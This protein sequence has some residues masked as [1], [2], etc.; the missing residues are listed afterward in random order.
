MRLT[1]FALALTIILL[2]ITSYLAWEGQQEIKGLKREREFD[3]EQLRAEKTAKPDQGSLIPLPSAPAASITP[4]PSPGTIAL[5][6]TAPPAEAMAGTS[7]LPGGGLTIP[8][9]VAEAESKGIS[10]NTVTPLQKQILASLPIAKVKTVV[11]EQGF[12]VLDAGSKQGLKRG[13]KFEIR[14][15]NAVLA[16]ITLTDA[17]EEAEAVADLDFASIPSGVEVEPGDE[18]IAPVVR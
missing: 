17:I 12:V 2:A 6:P 4:P 9:S 10:T 16:K 5:A 15:A 8:K 18:I 1:H 11:K 13:Q 7:T 3:K 14:R